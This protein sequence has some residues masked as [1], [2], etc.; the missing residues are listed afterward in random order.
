M[1]HVPETD[2]TR[3][4]A[5]W[6]RGPVLPPQGCVDPLLLVPIRSKISQAQLAA[7]NALWRTHRI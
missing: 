7:Q 3:Y 2:E 1:E 5:K 4:R 6:L